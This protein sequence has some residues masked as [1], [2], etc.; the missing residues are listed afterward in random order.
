MGSFNGEKYLRPAIESILAQTISDFEFLAIDDGSTDSTF[1]IMQEYARRDSRVI[2]VSHPNQGVTKSVNKLMAMSR[3]KLIARMD[4]DD[5][6]MPDRFAKQIAFLDANP[7]CVCVGCM[8]QN[9]SPAGEFLPTPP[10]YPGHA[11]I[12][13]ELMQGK[14]GAL[15]QPAAM[16]R[17]EAMDKVGGYCD[18]FRTAQDLDLFLRLAEIGELANVP[19]V[20]LHYRIHP[21]STNHARLDQQDADVAA[22]LKEAYARRGL[23]MPWYTLNWRTKPALERRRREIRSALAAG[24]YER[25]REKAWVVLK[26]APGRL[27]SWS[28]FASTL[29]RLG[30]AGV[31]DSGTCLP[32]VTG[33]AKDRP[34][35]ANGPLISVLMS[36]FNGDRYLRAAMESILGQTFGDFEFL[37][38]DDGSTDS[39]PAVLQEYARRDPRLRIITQQNQGLTKNLNAGLRMSRGSLIARMDADDISLPLRFEK[40]VAYLNAHPDCVCV[41]SYVQLISTD[42]EFL[43]TPPRQPD[44]AAIMEQLMQGK[45]EFLSHPTIMM[46]RDAVEKAGGYR[47]QFRTAQDLDLYL[48]LVEIGELANVPEVLLHYRVHGQNVHRKHIDQNDQDIAMILKEAYARRG[49]K[50]PWY[51]LN[52]RTKPALDRRRA[53]AHAAMATGDFTLARQKAWEVLRGSPKRMDS[54]SM[55]AKAMLRIRGSGA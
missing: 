38:F 1:A 10:R 46:R 32:I 5:I 34:P 29:L 48:R 53:E 22:I 16:I 4:G 6:C 27:D 12:D 24:H 8:V 30:K 9:I 37:V 36:T 25:A 33:D 3:G 44:Q 43:T 41:G 39:T 18:R 23:K 54:W 17:R 51:T 31:S 13:H 52:W 15:P 40:Q 2:A 35:M 20:L 14:G 11:R 21:E 50:M 55:F 26:A 7:K 42:G 19:E 47:E 49:I 45:A 28:L